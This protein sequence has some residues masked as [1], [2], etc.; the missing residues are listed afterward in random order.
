MQGKMLAVVAQAGLAFLAWY[1]AQTDDDRRAMQA[2]C[3]REVERTAMQLAK[4]ASNTA[5]F[6]ERR[7]RETVSV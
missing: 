4:A 2:R 6:A 7:Y 3:W 5:A 1:L